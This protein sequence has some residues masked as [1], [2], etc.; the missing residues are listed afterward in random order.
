M[1]PRDSDSATK[2]RVILSLHLSVGWTHAQEQG[3][4]RRN[5]GTRE[6]PG[7]VIAGDVTSDQPC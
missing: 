4:G 5:K 1:A 7:Q 3:V 2:P 6:E